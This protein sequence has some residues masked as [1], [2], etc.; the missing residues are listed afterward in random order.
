METLQI[1]KQYKVK[2]S[3]CSSIGIE[4]NPIL[5]LNYSSNNREKAFK[6]ELFSGK[7]LSGQIL[8]IQ[9]NSKT[10]ENSFRAVFFSGLKY[11]GFREAQHIIKEA[12]MVSWELGF[13]VAFSNTDIHV[14]HNSGFEKV[15]KIFPFYNYELPLLC[16]ELSW[17]GMNKIPEN[18]L[19]P[20]NLNP[21]KILS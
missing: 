8:I 1:N 2:T 21:Y 11:S 19:F 5:K 13:V 20:K 12:L 15:S 17:N 18:L 4:Q 16:Y 9:L 14:F 7:N 3:I 6:L 10:R